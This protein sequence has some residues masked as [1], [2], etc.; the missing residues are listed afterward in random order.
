MDKKTKYFEKQYLHYGG[1]CSECGEA[2]HPIL[3]DDVE[4]FGECPYNGKHPEV[5]ERYGLGYM[6]GRGA[7]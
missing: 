7:A 5:K 6:Q 2:V 4:T 3:N 1:F